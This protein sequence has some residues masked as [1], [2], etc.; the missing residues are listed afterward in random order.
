MPTLYGTITVACLNDVCSVAT[1][2]EWFELKLIEFIFTVLMPC[3]C[4]WMS[5]FSTALTKLVQ[6]P[7]KTALK[8]S[9]W[10]SG[11]PAAW[12]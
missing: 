8:C 7:L 6:E 11:S 2:I 5:S 12:G 10:F 9:V 1:L 4:W 3:S